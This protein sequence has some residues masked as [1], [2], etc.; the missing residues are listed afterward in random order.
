MASQL[1][2]KDKIKREK[3]IKVAPFKKEIKKTNPHKHNNYFE[4]IYLSHG[5]GYHNIDMHK[6]AITPPVMFFVRTSY[7]IS[8]KN[9]SETSLLN[10]NTA[11][12]IKNITS[13]KD[14]A[15][16]S[17]STTGLGIQDMIK[18]ATAAKVNNNFEG[19]VYWYK[20]AA[21]AGDKSAYINLGNVYDAFS[22]R[23]PNIDSAIYWYLK[24]AGNDVTGYDTKQGIIYLQQAA[25]KNNPPCM[26]FLGH[27]CM[28]GFENISKDDEKAVYWLKKAMSSRNVFAKGFYGIMLYEGRG[29][30][31]AN[32]AKGHALISQVY[33][34]TNNN[35]WKEELTNHP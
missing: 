6:Y 2:I 20:Q 3:M 15:N 19:T 1:L 5:S 32:R 25:N 12:S 14:A 29:G 23:Q 13:I 17:N 34:T 24:A 7:F 27:L 8:K 28:N 22:G 21:L 35:Y 10:T 26:E 4:I 11:D 18:K 30:L 9:N 33:N 16:T 31:A